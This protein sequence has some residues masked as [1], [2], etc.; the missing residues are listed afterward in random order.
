MWTLQDRVEG[1]VVPENWWK[2]GPSVK[3]HWTTGGRGRGDYGQIDEA[4]QD[5]KWNW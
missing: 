2:L 1:K 5:E 4:G 3:G